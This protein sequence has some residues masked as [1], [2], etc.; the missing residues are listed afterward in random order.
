MS[1]NRL[2]FGGGAVC[3]VIVVAVLFWPHHPV[4]LP[5]GEGFNVVLISIDT[6]RADHLGCY[7][8]PTI[9]TPHIDRLAMEGTTFTEC[10]TPVPITLPAHSSMMT[11]TY[12]FVHGVRDNGGFILHED[13]ETLAEALS[14]AGYITA[15][16]VGAAVLNRQTGINQGFDDYGDMYSAK[17]AVPQAGKFPSTR[18][19]DEVIDSAITWLRAKA[20][21]KFF[22]FVH[23]FDPHHPY[24]APEPF[25]SEYADPYVAEVAYTDEQ[26]GRLLRTLTEMGL[27][28]RTLIVLTADHGEGRGDHDEDTHGCFVY[29]TTLSVPLILWCP[30]RIPANRRV[31]AQTRITDILPTILT[32]V[33]V[34]S[35]QVV[36]GVSLLPLIHARADDPNLPA[37]AESMYPTYN[38]GYSHLLAMRAGGWKYIHAP[39]P[40][41][42][43]VSVDPGERQNL[44]ETQP[45][46]V[47]SLRGQLRALL[48]EAPTVAGT[49]GAQAELTP[50]AIEALRSLGYVGGTTAN[51]AVESGDPT[52]LLELAGADPKD[53]TEEIR[54]TGQALHLFE[55]RDFPAVEKVLRELIE[56]FPESQES[57]SWAHN[58]LGMAL[59]AQEKDYGEAI[60]CYRKALEIHP[61]DA[62]ALSN[63][64][65]ALARIG[66][67]DEAI[68]T[69]ESALRIEPDLAQTHFNLAMALR[70][71]GRSDEADEHLQRAAEL[72]PQKF[73]A[74]LDSR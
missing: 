2:F 28:R 47:A 37:Y 58:R 30:E 73:R 64:G 72:A 14:A 1:R 49:G 48:E 67:I 10:T 8:H 3:A 59:V 51:P 9:K 70:F 71:R 11:G 43:R 32:F 36:Q 60:A 38:Y 53:H 12:P 7:G 4:P 46:R 65:V 63:L 26:I 18:R 44:A 23:L 27:D 25:A 50:R 31:T 62:A 56:R 41:L 15:G 5:S 35:P 13:N 21:R 24:E 52:A 40:E 34:P 22:L 16:V 55:V 20:S 17:G 45:D 33:G 69:Y 19:A 66:N 29:D 68:E 74:Y 61:D 39:S 42:Y 6:A 54:L 57:F